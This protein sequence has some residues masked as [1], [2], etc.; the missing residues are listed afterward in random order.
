MFVHQ[1]LQLG[2]VAVG[3]SGGHRRYQV[4]DDGGVGAPFR[5]GAF[6]GVVD[7][8]R[9][10][11]RNIVQ[12]HLRVAGLR[13]T[14]ALARQPFQSA[15]LADM[16][17]RIRPKHL[18]QPAVIGDVMVRRRQI[19]VVI[20]R[21]GVGAK[22]ARRLQ[23]H[24]HIA[25]RQ[26]GNGQPVAGAIDLARRI[27][28]GILQFRPHGCRKA[29]VPV[30]IGPPFH[31]AGRP[32]QLLLGK[33][34]RVVAAP[35]NDALHQRVAVGGNILNPIAGIPQGAQDVD[36]RGRRVQADGVAD[37]RVF[38]GIV[39][40]NDGDTLVGVGLAA[41]NGVPRRQPRQIVHP[42]GHGGVPLDPG[43]G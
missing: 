33:R 30:R 39:A 4:V 23:P 7:D 41:Q 2:D 36:G 16:D 28:P 10:E 40:Q 43:G 37:A 15:M 26:P 5:L 11:Q 1:L 29:G 32:P 6:A 34:I 20:D 3:I 31:M 18:A 22:A 42:V 12:R 8:E 19:R 25:H 35:L 38:G 24:E 13:Q 17:H 27:P 14:D 9:V 21:D